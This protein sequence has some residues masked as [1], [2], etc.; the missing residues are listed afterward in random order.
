[1]MVKHRCFDIGMP[2]QY[3]HSADIVGVLQQ[4]GGEDMARDG[5]RYLF[6]RVGQ[7]KLPTMQVKFGI[8]QEIDSFDSSC[9]AGGESSAFSI[10]AL[11]M[12]CSIINTPIRSY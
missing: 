1:M 7:K 6:V 12:I 11:E 10:F 2:E 3:L 8:D 5:R 4:M 9:S